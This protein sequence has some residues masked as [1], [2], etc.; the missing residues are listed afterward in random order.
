SIQALLAARLERLGP[1]ERSVLERA[2]IVGRDFSEREAAALLPNEIQSTLTGHLEALVRRR[3]ITP[4]P[5]A[6]GR[7]GPYQFPPVL[8][9]EA[10]YGGSAK[11]GGGELH[12][13][14]A[15]WLENTPPDRT[16]EIEEILGYPLER[17]YWLMT[18]LAPADAVASTLAMR[19]GG[20]LAAAGG[21]AL[22]RGDVYAAVGQL[23]RAAALLPS[24]VPG[25]SDLLQRLGEAQR[26]A[27]N[28]AHAAAALDA[29]TALAESSGQARL[30]S[31]GLIERAHLRIA[32][33]PEGADEEARQLAAA[34]IRQFERLGDE[35][36]LARAWIL[37][38]DLDQ[39]FCRWA[40][41]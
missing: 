28:F 21:R 14:F 38:S 19:A 33:D 9:Q 35:R 22:D 15:D 36:G 1:G 2:A 40:R 5:G 24:T 34:A 8:I 27:G 29:P 17:A 11:R 6:V 7:A 20:H 4:A 18:E 26:K 16:T 12:E 31:Y 13:R 41:Y 23:E 30:L 10:G 3:Y 39:H 32:V 37:W 25:R